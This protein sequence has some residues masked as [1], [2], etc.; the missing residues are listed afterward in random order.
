MSELDAFERIVVSLNEAALDGDR[1]PAVSALIDEAIGSAGN[2]FSYGYGSSFE[3]VQ[4]LFSELLYRGQRREE[5]E[6]EYFDV[7]YRWDERVPRIR[8]LP[9]SRVVHC[10]ET[11]TEEE[12]KTSAAYN[13]ML[14]RGDFQNSLSVRL[15][16][17]HGIRITW[18]IADP[19]GAGDWSSVRLDAI[20]R[21]LPHLRQFVN[22]RQALVDSQAL[23]KS[24]TGLLDICRSGIVQ[25]DGR[26]RIVAANDF[27]RDLLRRGDGLS[28]RGGV[29]KAW[30]LDDDASLPEAGGT[31]TRAAGQFR[32]SAARRCCCAR[33]SRRGSWC[34]SA[35]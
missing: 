27:A 25:L 32:G 31:G 5:I 1:W 22:V 9:D 20:Q 11:L 24:L 30:S 14:P 28:D 8:E 17:A 10:R 26:G 16:G 2:M 18:G 4:I 15:Q 19:V 13:E 34:M 7:Y 12:L 23:G 35:R 6:R 29:L 33:R 21:I 3:D